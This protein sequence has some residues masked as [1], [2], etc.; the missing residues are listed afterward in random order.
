MTTDLKTKGSVCMSVRHTDWLLGTWL[1]PDLTVWLCSHPSSKYHYIRARQWF[2]EYTV[3]NIIV[4]LRP[5]FFSEF[6]GLFGHIGK[7]WDWYS[8]FRIEIHPSRKP[9][10][11]T[12][13]VVNPLSGLF[14]Q[15]IQNHQITAD[16]N[17]PQILKETVATAWVDGNISPGKG[18]Y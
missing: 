8:S 1:N 3:F 5:F 2:M 17:G 6:H 4:F 18:A 12:K 15:E 14:I 10:S 7:I 13:C 9:G 16:N 11:V